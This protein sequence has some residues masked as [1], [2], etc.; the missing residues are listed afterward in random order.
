MCCLTPG[1][2]LIEGMWDGGMEGAPVVTAP[3]LQ[4]A[5]TCDKSHAGGGVLTKSCHIFRVLTLLS[6]DK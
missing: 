1:G 3:P 5:L 6:E 2:Q 4:P